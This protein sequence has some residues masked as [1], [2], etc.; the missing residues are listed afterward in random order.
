MRAP[1]AR[2][3]GAL[4][5]A[6][7]VLTEA[8]L[9][10]FLLKLTALDD[11]CWT[12]IGAKD[13][14]GYGRVRIDKVAHAAHRIS[15]QH[16]VGA[17]PEGH[18]LDHICRRRDCVNPDH[19]EPVTRQENVQRGLKGRLVTHCAQGHEY[20]EQNTRIRANGRRACRACNR[21]AARRFRE[22]R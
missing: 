7:G 18:D 2:C 13:T 20:D 15:Y 12:W 16:F 14:G 8:V 10:R 21:E 1:G 6:P 17:I 19:L 9:D 5:Y 3:P 11:G 22:R 4:T